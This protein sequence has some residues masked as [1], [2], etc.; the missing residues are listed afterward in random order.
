[1]SN[2][3]RVVTSDKPYGEWDFPL[4]VGMDYYLNVIWKDENGVAADLDGY[5]IEME[6][7]YNGQPVLNLNTDDGDVTIV[8]VSNESTVTV[9]FP[10]AKTRAL[11]LAPHQYFYRVRDPGGVRTT[12]FAGNA[13]LIPS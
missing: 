4:P 6:L 10:Y 12:V 3:A 9:H 1:M 7:R 8:T 11:V 5:Y 13:N 2:S